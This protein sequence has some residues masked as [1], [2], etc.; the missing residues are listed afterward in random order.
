MYCS[1]NDF[2]E[3]YSEF[4]IEVINMSYFTVTIDNVGFKLNG[5]AE[6][7]VIARPIVKDHGPWPRKLEPRERVSLFC[8]LDQLIELPDTLKIK[9]AFVETVCGT[10]CTG[11]S[12]ALKKLIKFV[13]RERTKS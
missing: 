1:M 6:N 9:K 8:S 13:K 3:V 10:T 7:L 12:N 2:S 11:T 4:I 5:K